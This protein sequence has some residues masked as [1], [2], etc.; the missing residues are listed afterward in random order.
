VTPMR[1]LRSVAAWLVIVAAETVH[2][3]LRGILLVPLVGDLRARQIGVPIGSLIIFAV[4]C[5]CIRWIAARTTLQLLGVGV[6][7][8]VL[9]VL[10]EIGLGRLVLGL[11]LERIAED[12][13]PARGGFLAS[14]LLFMAVSP[15]LA[16]RLRG[17]KPRMLLHRSD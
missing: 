6:L 5:L 10:F 3:V 4:A 8:V 15:L 1:L 2:G 11:P 14:G 16:A 17:P 9:T 13:D 12:Y 7:W